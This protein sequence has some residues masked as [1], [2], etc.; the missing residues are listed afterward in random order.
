[1]GSFHLCRRS[2]AELFPSIRSLT[3]TAGTRYQIRNCRH[4]LSCHKCSGP[5]RQVRLHHKDWR[6]LVDYQKCTVRFSCHRSTVE[7]QYR[8]FPEVSSIVCCDV[9]ITRAI[10]CETAGIDRGTARFALSRNVNNVSSRRN[11]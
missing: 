7:K 5:R 8:G 2:Y 11:C 10:Q 1:M 4:K 3:L 6:R 9:Q